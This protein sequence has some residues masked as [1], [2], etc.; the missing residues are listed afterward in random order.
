MNILNQVKSE[1]YIDE[2]KTDSSPR[3]VSI[4][5]KDMN[6][7]IKSIDQLPRTIDGTVF[8]ELTNNAVNKRLKVY[9][10]NLGIKE[11]TCITSYS[12]FIFI[13]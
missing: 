12:L 10:N 7:I 1:I 3:Y 13:S 8:G 2:H 9:C 5:Q 11:I 6:H 4:S